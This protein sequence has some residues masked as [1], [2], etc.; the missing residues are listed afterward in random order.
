MLAPT[1]RGCLVIADITGYTEYLAGSELEHAQDV[2]A[3]L[4]RT[5]VAAIRP[6]LRLA[7]LEGDAAFA[8]APQGTIEGPMLLD[9][10]EGC[11]LGFRKRLR[12]IA[13]ATTC[14]CNA[15]RRIPMLNLKFFVHD[16]EF[17]RARIAGR[18]ELAGSDVI[19]VHRLLKNTVAERLGLSGYALFT[20]ACLQAVGLDAVALGMQEHAETYE[21]IGEVRAFVHNLARRWEEEQA[22]RRIY[23]APGKGDLELVFDL[24]APPAVVW[25]YLTSPAKRLRF[26]VGATRIDQTNPAGRRGPGTTTHCAHGEEVIVEEV[27]DWRP[28]DYFTTRFAPMGFAIDETAEFAATDRG[29]RVTLRAKIARTKKAREMWPTL[30]EMY[31][32]M[33]REVFAH[34]A[35]VLADD[36]VGD[37]THRG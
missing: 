15:C 17:V 28:F 30:R 37:A 20:E 19:L 2:L 5:V 4:M 6:V 1:E 23:V 26:Q 24:P 11:Y 35:A 7:K 9:V 22:R 3:D 32:A 29:T 31:P 36:G 25:D 33:M 27:L 8:H 12:D 14:Q 13:H 18:E 16:G 10:V 34:L 21:H